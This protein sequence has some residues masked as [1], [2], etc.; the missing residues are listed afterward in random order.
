MPSLLGLMGLSDLIPIDI[1]GAD[2]SSIMLGKKGDKPASA[3]YLNCSGPHGGRRG[4]RTH[5]CTFT[6]TP[7]KYGN[8]DI[9]LFDNIAD[10]YQLKNIA[11]NN[12]TIVHN[13][14]A[15][16]KGWLQKTNDPWK[17]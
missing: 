13:L 14:T 10:P 15:E 3:L 5:R 12:P 4:L 11:E 6:I 16:L 1:E 7:D 9:L 17:L 2:Y 8:K